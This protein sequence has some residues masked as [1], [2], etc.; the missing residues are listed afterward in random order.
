MTGTVRETRCS[1]ECVLMVNDGD[2]SAVP[3]TTE[4]M[5]VVPEILEGIIDEFL[6]QAELE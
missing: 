3:K 1:S 2:A 6:R 5:W 4:L